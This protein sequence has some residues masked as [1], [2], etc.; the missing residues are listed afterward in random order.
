MTAVYFDTSVFLAI[1]KKE[2]TARR[3][4]ELLEQLQAEH[5]RI[6][7][8]ILT[9][10]ECSVLGFRRGTVAR[11]TTTRVAKIARIVG[12][13]PDIALTA[14]KLEAQLAD[15]GRETETDREDKKRRKWDCFHIATAQAYKC[16]TLF[17]EDKPMQG[18]GPMLG[19]KD[20]SILPPRP[21]PKEPELFEEEEFSEETKPAKA[22]AARIPA[23]LR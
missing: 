21:R 16:G 20:I 5:I 14:A 12:I 7:T 11:D 2:T 9:L 13:T 23:D 19:L 3:I 1:L 18:R 8:S 17:A 22:A 4:R 10:Q 15:H 6:Y